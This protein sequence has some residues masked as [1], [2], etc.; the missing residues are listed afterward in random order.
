MESGLNYVWQQ[1]VM[2]ALNA[3][4]ASL[5]L[6]INIAQNAIAA[7]LQVSKLMDLEEYMAI[8]DALR[9]LDLLIVQPYKHERSE[10]REQTI[11]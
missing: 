9:T 10:T 1:S 11:S 8:R 2:A 6:K 4:D 7:R 5:P 3:F